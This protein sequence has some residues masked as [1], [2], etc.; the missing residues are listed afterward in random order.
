MAW[1][2]TEDF[3]PDPGAKPGTNLNAV[4]VMGPGGGDF[5]L[6]RTFAFRMYCD[7]GELMYEGRSSDQDFGPLEDFGTPNAGATEIRYLVKGKWETL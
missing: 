6:P 3:M 1:E 2:I 5:S 7:D 4:G